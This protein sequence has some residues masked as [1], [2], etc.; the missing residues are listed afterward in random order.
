VSGVPPDYFSETGQLWGTPLYDW[1]RL[2]ADGFTW[3]VRRLRGELRRVD[4]L[5]VDHFRGFQGYWSIPAAARSARE[6]HWEPGPGIR[7]F[8]AV[9]ASMGRLPL[10]AEDLGDI[11]DDVRELLRETGY[12]GMRVLQ[13]GF[14]SADS[15]HRPDRIPANSVAYTGTHDNDTTRGWFESL[16]A[17]ERERVLAYVGGGPED[18]VWNLIRVLYTCAADRVVVP[19]QDVLGL[20]SEGRMNTPAV[21]EGNWAF[22]VGPGALTEENA[23]RLSELVVA[24]GRDQGASAAPTP[25][26]P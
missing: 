22:R 20:G 17:E 26:S 21:A 13:F 2:E 15:Y 18:V 12:P 10:V 19:I 24:T 9:E 14:G 3:W 25:R 1:G 6:G 11:G 5:R 8:H 7:L 23:A 4:L 16:G